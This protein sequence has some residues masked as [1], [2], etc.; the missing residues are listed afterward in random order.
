MAGVETGSC[1]EGEAEEE[2]ESTCR[3]AQAEVAS[4]STPYAHK[5]TYT[6]LAG[7]AWLELKQR[8]SFQGEFCIFGVRSKE[9]QAQISIRYLTAAVQRTI[10]VRRHQRG[11]ST[12]QKVRVSVRTDRDSETFMQVKCCSIAAVYWSTRRCCNLTH[13]Q[14]QQGNIETLPNNKCL[15]K[16]M[17]WQ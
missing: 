12:P 13:L 5:H 17:W 1:G 11:E 2:R 14:F 8:K 6:S 15:I 3:L 16:V 4:R 10:Q 9:I 7:K